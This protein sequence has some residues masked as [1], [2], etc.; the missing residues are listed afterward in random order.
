[1]KLII[2]GLLI[3][4]GLIILY[5]SLFKMKQ[6]DYRDRSSVGISGFLAWELL[7]KVI[8]RFHMVLQRVL[9]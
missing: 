8:N 5:F 2:G 7:M 9:Y 4:W 1:M 6:E 3:L